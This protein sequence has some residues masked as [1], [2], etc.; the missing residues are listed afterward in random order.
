MQILKRIICTFVLLLLITACGGGG[1]KDDDDS[2][3]TPLESAV[4]DQGKWGEVEWQ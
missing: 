1:G 4:W 3:P 2:S